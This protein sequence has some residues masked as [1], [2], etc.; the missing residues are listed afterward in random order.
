MEGYYDIK[1][2]NADMAPIERAYLLKGF[3]A[4]KRPLQWI[5]FFRLCVIQKESQQK[6][7]NKKNKI[8]IG[9]TIFIG[10]LL[11]IMFQINFIFL[12]MFIVGICCIV[13]LYRKNRFN[14]KYGNGYEF[15]AEY[16]SAFLTLI[17]EELTSSGTLHLTANINK[18]TSSKYLKNKTPAHSNTRGFISGQNLF[19]EKEIAQGSCKLKDGSLLNF[20]FVDR[21]RKRVINKK[22]LSGKHKTKY[23]YK[24]VYPFVMQMQISK[25][26]YSIKSK[27]N[28]EV[29][30]NQDNDFYYVKVQR[31][32]D[33]RKEQPKLYSQTR[34]SN[35]I[36]V[37]PVEYFVLEVT[38]LLNLSLGQF[39]LKN[40]LSNG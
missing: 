32:F 35:T 19:F 27:I 38:N 37:F 11:L 25:S 17:E 18:T 22:S 30:I 7:M 16:F 21:T 4:K 14:K 39:Q 10:I 15:F 29:K 6:K 24:S 34:N 33:I 13:I 5:K 36:R 3:S 2:L 12:A 26:L 8:F 9:I 28:Q 31:K 20:S 40:N 23:K 1:K